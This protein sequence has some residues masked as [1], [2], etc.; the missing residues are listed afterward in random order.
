VFELFQD[1][2]G[3]NIDDYRQFSDP[4]AGLSAIQRFLQ[5]AAVVDGKT[6]VPVDNGVLELRGTS[7]C[8]ESFVLDRDRA[9]SDE[10]VSLLGLDNHMIAGYLHRYK[11]LDANE[12]GVR[13]LSM[14]ERGGI[15]SLWQITCQSDKGHQITSMVS[16]GVD[17][18]EQRYPTLEKLAG[19]V[20]QFPCA[21]GQG[22][23]V[24]GGHLLH[25][26]IEPMLHR[27]L[28]HRGMVKD[29]QAYQSALVG[30]VEV[31]KT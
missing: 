11:S 7:G 25:D 10:T 17:T 5:V 12:I 30:W 20:F 8:E 3:F 18:N 28:L 4:S 19:D 2:G 26:I 22:S 21:T 16:L 15:L 24:N 1:L 14:L 13:V 9:I 29:G 6:L 23:L 27:D 31:T